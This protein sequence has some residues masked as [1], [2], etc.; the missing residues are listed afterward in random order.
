MARRHLRAQLACL[1]LISTPSRPQKSGH[2]RAQSTFTKHGATCERFLFGFVR[3]AIVVFFWLCSI[4]N[5]RA[6]TS[7]GYYRVLLQHYLR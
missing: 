7:V 4:G 1:D 3:L 2:K 6:Q 5:R